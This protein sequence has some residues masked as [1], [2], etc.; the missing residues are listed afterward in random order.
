[1]EAWKE[2]IDRDIKKN[3]K[4]QILVLF[5]NENEQRFYP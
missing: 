2:E 5:F 3:G 4:P 1:V